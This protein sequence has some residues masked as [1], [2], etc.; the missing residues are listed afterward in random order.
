MARDFKN[1]KAWQDAEYRELE[2]LRS[3]TAKTLFG[4]IKTVKK[5]VLEDNR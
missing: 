3:V 1:I 5:E 4:R 2:D